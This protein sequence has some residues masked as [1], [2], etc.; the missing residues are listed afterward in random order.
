MSRLINMIRNMTRRSVITLA[1]DD[2]GD[3]PVQQIT[4]LGKATECEMISPYGLHANLPVGVTLLTTWSVQGQEDNRVGMGYTPKL[5]PKELPE[6]ELVLYHPLTGSKIHYKNNGDIDIDVTGDNGDLNVTIKKD[7]NITVNG[8]ASIN[9][10]GNAAVDIDGDAAIDIDGTA[11]VD[12]PT[13]NW[14]GDINL[15]GK[16][17]I[18]GDLEVSGSSTLSA[19][20]TSN[21]KDISDTH[22]HVGSPTAP[23]GS[24]TPTGAVV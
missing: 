20:V 23:S 13:T 3:Y 10:V 24:V 17:N 6:G 19:T 7:L 9:V 1:G 16:L 18:N 14:T 15:T 12:C 4:Y 11:T 8:N 21:G 5:R 2:A 22:T